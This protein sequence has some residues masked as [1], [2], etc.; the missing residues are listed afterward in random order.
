MTP[1]A[2]ILAGGKSRRLG[3]DKAA[4]TIGGS[5]LLLRTANLAARHCSEIWVS[6]RDPRQQG[7]DLPWMADEV[8]GVGPMG[9]VI[10]G[11]KRLGGP[12]LVLACDMPLLGDQEIA[13]LLRQRKQRP[14]Q[15]IMTTYQQAETG[16]VESLVAVYEPEALPL[17]E[18][19]L[20][21]GDYK[22]AN[23]VPPERRCCISYAQDH[24][25][26]FFNINYPADL[27]LLS[28]FLLTA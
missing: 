24:A 27:A 22:L 2:L 16:F 9:G 11:L 3:R 8:P 5:N 12:L 10:T 13:V 21:R 25:L 26:P 14:A 15:A 28:Q 18:Q 23:A 20:E 17:L 7:V 6:G 4:E 19:A 1:R